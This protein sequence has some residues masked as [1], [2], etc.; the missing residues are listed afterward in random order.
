MEASGEHP[1]TQEQV[2]VRQV[3]HFQTSWTE[4]QAGAPGTFTVQLILDQG[5]EEYVVRP[6]ADDLDVLY[7]LLRH[8]EAVYLDMNRKVLIFGNHAVG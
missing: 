4:G 6:T 3:T 5:A 2:R 1:V 7:G 8:E